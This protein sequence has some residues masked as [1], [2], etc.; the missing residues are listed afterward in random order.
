MSSV[1]ITYT[2]T[3]AKVG[4]RPCKKSLS[5]QGT[6]LELKMTSVVGQ[7]ELRRPLRLYN[8]LGGVAGCNTRKAA[9]V[10]LLAE[11]TV[12][13]SLHYCKVRNRGPCNLASNLLSALISLSDNESTL[14]IA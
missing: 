9:V 13:N 5:S 14:H 7:N 2:T 10:V 4:R 6:E 3:I 1:T 8:Y 12:E 11:Y